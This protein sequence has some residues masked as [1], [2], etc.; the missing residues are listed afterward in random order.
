[1]YFLQILYFQYQKIYHFY[2]IVVLVV[3]KWI[4]ESGCK[5][6]E[7]SYTRVRPGGRPSNRTILPKVRLTG[8]FCFLGVRLT[9]Q[10]E[11]S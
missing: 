6:V 8:Q 4:Y 3:R 2:A 10:L 5:K 7:F 11:I 1:M 9:G